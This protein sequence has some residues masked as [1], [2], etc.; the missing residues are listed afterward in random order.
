MELTALEIADIAGGFG[1][2][3]TL[4]G[5]W[6]AYRNALKIMQ[7]QEFNKAASDLR[8]SFAPQLFYLRS[9]KSTE[10]SNGGTEETREYLYDSFVNCHATELCK[11][12]FF[13]IS[14]SRDIATYD[15]KCEEYEEHLYQGFTV[16]LNGQ[17]PQEYFIEQINGLLNFT[18]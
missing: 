2:V 3:G 13:I 15:K 14:S 9:L 1:I 4:L 16:D 10:G 7:R 17:S 6:I 18:K 12:R 5:V 8:A 11:F